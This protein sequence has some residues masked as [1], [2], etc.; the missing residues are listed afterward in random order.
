M[1]KTFKKDKNSSLTEWRESDISNIEE[2][3][4]I[5]LSNPPPS[6]QWI[7]AIFTIAGSVGITINSIFGFIYEN[8]MA[9]VIIYIFIY[10]FTLLN[11]S[12]IRCLLYEI[13]LMLEIIPDSKGQKGRIQELEEEIDVLKN[14]IEARIPAQAGHYRANRREFDSFKTELSISECK[15]DVRLIKTVGAEPHLIFKWELRVINTTE[16]PAT[17]AKFIYSGDKNAN[18]Y[19]EVLIDGHKV[20]VEMSQER[21]VIGDYRFLNIPFDSLLYHNRT[22]DII[23]KYTLSEH[24]FNPRFD[25]IWLV[26]DALGFK[27][28]SQ[29]RIRFFSDGNI[30]NQNTQGVLRS[31]KLSGECDTTGDEPIVFE[32]IGENE[33]GFQCMRDRDLQGRGYLLIL[34]NDTE[35]LEQLPEY[36]LDIPVKKK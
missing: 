14:A 33:S 3:Q 10:T 35:Q 20:K 2:P 23:I 28:M 5:L 32:K 4:R 18:S 27:D 31:Y 17:N 26:P 36:L 11:S 12:R 9:T 25:Y 24:K 7:C 15:L 30:V 6:V 29:F 34:I 8:K 16:T 21:N 13:L 19:P 1:K 22:A